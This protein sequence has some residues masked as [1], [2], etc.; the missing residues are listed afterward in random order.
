VIVLSYSI[1]LAIKLS[2]DFRA[3]VN[4]HWYQS[5]FPNTRISRTK[6][7]EFEVVTTHNGYRLGG[8]IDGSVTGRGADIIIIDDPMKPMDALSDS[9]RQRVIDLYNTTLHTRLNN[10]LTGAIILVMQRLRPDDL[11]V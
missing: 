8:S 1:E 11:V 6:N 3:L 4:S 9:K 2:N 5:L 7:T 10:K